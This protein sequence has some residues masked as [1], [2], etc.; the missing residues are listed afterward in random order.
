M[1]KTITRIEIIFILTVLFLVSCG[2]N[3]VE[4]DTQL[5]E[6]VF[7]YP[8]NNSV[9]GDTITFRISTTD[10]ESVTKVEFYVDDSHIAESDDEIEPYEYTMDVSNFEIGSLHT[11]Y[12]KAYDDAGN[13]SPSDTIIFYYKW[14]LLLED[15]DE[16]FERD[17]DRVYIRSTSSTLDF[18]VETNGNWIDPHDWEGE[19]IDCALFL[20]TDQNTNTGLNPQDSIWYSVGDIGPDYVAVIGLEGDSLWAWEEIYYAEEDTTYFSWNKLFDFEYLDLQENTNHFEVSLRLSDIGN[21]DIIDIVTANLTFDADSTYW[22][23]A[24]NEG[25]ATY[26][27]D[28][29]YIGETNQ[30][31]NRQIVNKIPSKLNSGHWIGKRNQ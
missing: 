17:L 14:I 8:L 30:G 9:V 6:V 26:Q 4:P 23:W 1:K 18:R 22:D 24:P 2:D 12:S 20:D 15:D 27:I 16:P 7:T 10:N 3:S 13:F 11:V 29:L 25:H 21:P 31:M 28:G 19:S 5:P